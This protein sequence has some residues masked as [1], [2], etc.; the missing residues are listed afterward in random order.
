[1]KKAYVLIWTIFLILLI[2]LWMSLTL[3]ISSYTP[4]IIQDSY[5]YLQAQILSHNATQFS[6]YFLY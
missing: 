1:M 5:Y 3:N 4:K 2:S 6:K